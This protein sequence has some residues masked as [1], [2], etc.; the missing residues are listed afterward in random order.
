M[1]QVSDNFGPIYANTVLASNG[2]GAVTFQAVGSALRISNIFFQVSSS[3]LQAQVFIYKSQIA[4]GN[5]IFNSQSG[6]TGGNAKGNVDLFDGEKIIVRWVG[7]DVGSTAT[8]TFTG[9]KIPFQDMRPSLL[10]FDDMIAAG[11]GSLVYPALKSPNYVAGVSGWKIDRAGNAEFANATLRGIFEADGA[12]NSYVRV[13]TTGG[14]GFGTAVIYERPPDLPNIASAEISP[15]VLT[16]LSNQPSGAGIVPDAYLQSELDCTSWT[17]GST[18]A[19]VRY[20]AMV[21]RTATHDGTVQPFVIFTTGGAA[22][23]PKTFDFTVDGNLHINGKFSRENAFCQQQIVGLASSTTPTQLTSLLSVFNSY[24]IFNGADTFTV[25]KPG[26]YKVGML[27][28]YSAQATAAGYRGIQIALNGSTHRRFKLPTSASVN[29]EILD[30]ELHYPLSLI[31]GDQIT[32]LVV[33]N[34]GAA[35]TVT[36]DCWIELVEN[37]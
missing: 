22:P 34:S 14:T 15:A 3:V 33:Q 1:P 11:D 10:T 20:P 25:T 16:A 17:F 24:G 8:A 35:L 9:Q 23:N 21:M 6:S 36:C 12:N 37:V 13:T 19:D 30:V 26:Q 4:D 5:I 7:G 28:T 18:A 31:A 29:N 32:F 2:N 27:A